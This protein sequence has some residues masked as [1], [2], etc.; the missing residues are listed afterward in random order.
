MKK[1]VL[2]IAFGAFVVVSGIFCWLAQHSF[3]LVHKSVAAERAYWDEVYSGIAVNPH[4]EFEC[5]EA[6]AWKK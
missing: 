3:F 5:M 4:N 6:E 2:H 1:A